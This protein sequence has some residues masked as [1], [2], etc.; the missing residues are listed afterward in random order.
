MGTWDDIKISKK[1]IIGFVALII[2]AS[3]VGVVG[4]NSL[5]GVGF[6][7]EKANDAAELGQLGEQY[8]SEMKGFMLVGHDDYGGRGK[9]P[10]QAIDEY[11][12][13]IQEKISSLK[14]K[15]ALQADID[16]I[17]ELKDAFTNYDDNLV[18]YIA[19]YEKQESAA[20][21]MDTAAAA[22]MPEINQLIADQ[23]NK[24]EEE[25]ESGLTATQLESRRSKLSQA[26]AIIDNI[27]AMRMA[28]FK[29][30]INEDDSYIEEFDTLYE[31]AKTLAQD[32]RSQFNDQ[33][34]I[35]QVNN[36]LTELE[37]YEAAKTTYVNKVDE[38]ATLNQKA[39]DYG[40]EFS[41]A[42]EALVDSQLTGLAAEQA[43]ANTMIVTFIAA[44]VLIG[45]ALAFFIT[46]SITSP[47]EKIGNELKG[48]ADSGDLSKRSTV[49]SKN[50]IGDMAASLN[51]MLD[52]VAAPVA[53]IADNAKIVANGDLTH[54][55]N[56]SNAKG[57]VKNLADGFTAMLDG[58]RETIAAVKTN[59][60]QVAS[61][62]EELSSSAEE[63]NA[64]MEEVGSTIQQVA[65]GSQNTAKDSENMINQV[66]QA[67]ESS[68]QGQQAS[69]EVSSKMQMIKTTTQEGADKIGALGEKSKEIGNIVDTIN[70]I[71]E[72]TNLLAL[73]A[74]IEAARAGEAGRGFAVVAD[75]VRKLAEESGQATH[76]ISNL[77]QGIQTEIESAVSSMDEN[78]KQ[79]DEGSQ[80]VEQAVQAFEAL[81][82]V[83]AAVSQSA[84][85][86]GSVAQEN[87]S[88]AEEVSASIQ[89]VTSSMQQV[90]SASE[91]MSNISSELQNIVD[92]FKIN[93][94]GTTSTSKDSSYK[95]DYKQHD[96][97][98]QQPSQQ[99]STAKHTPV[100]KQKHH[101]F[102]KKNQ[103]TETPTTTQSQENPES[104]KSSDS[105][106]QS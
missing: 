68:S 51:N 96:S 32:L 15:F 85:E 74:A 39:I 61:S 14:A 54:D 26:N 83:I 67:K 91:Q 77:I 5:S 12:P 27:N 20:D 89:E 103:K 56:V 16:K 43:S 13:I 55:L 90:A 1:L 92:G 81:P 64:S 72:Q 8:R 104:E 75:E 33:Y 42:A 7:A 29:Y 99:H 97:S 94:Q 80:G 37:N 40:G 78:T 60:Q 41:T 38:L 9:T 100:K 24:L 48:L 70:Q 31:E 63:V 35:D 66:Q 30:Q 95:Q 82:Q 86:V 105:P 106:T 73:N 21:D 19:A 57:D 65:S 11:R 71:S 102:N 88:G 18:D 3:A 47:L 28:N 45:I 98:Y 10:E 79:V 22:L 59:T 69:Q 46:R 53:D 6:R 101:F 25:I 2:V 58:L 76:Q 52:N 84:E 44:A 87:A 4:Y 23:D 17:N 36:V 93:D 62:A 34:N 50:E 49:T